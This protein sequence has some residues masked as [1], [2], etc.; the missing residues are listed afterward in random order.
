MA[1]LDK[2]DLKTIEGIGPAMEVKLKDLGINTVADLAARTDAA[3]VATLLASRGVDGARVKMW[4]AAASTPAADVSPS[5]VVASAR[6]VTPHATVL[7][8]VPIDPVA[9]PIPV[10]NREPT[11]HELNI[12]ARSI[13]SQHRALREEAIAAADTAATTALKGIAKLNRP[14][15]TQKNLRPLVR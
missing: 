2:N 8:A 15:R 4:I 1:D 5:A 3:D 7:V 10:L 12:Q 11:L 9:K 14:R 13:D 6:V